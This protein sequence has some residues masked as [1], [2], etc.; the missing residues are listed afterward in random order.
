MSRRKKKFVNT[1]SL[2]RY[3]YQQNTNVPNTLLSLKNIRNKTN[4][5]INNYFVFSAWKQ[6]PLSGK[7]VL[8]LHLEELFIFVPRINWLRFFSCDHL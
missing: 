2:L 8:H 6:F 7:P 4:E 1:S 3:K 5:F